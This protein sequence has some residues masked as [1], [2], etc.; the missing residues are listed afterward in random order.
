MLLLAI[1]TVEFGDERKSN[2]RTENEVFSVGTVRSGGPVV[3]SS[4]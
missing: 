1:R 4:F 2:V 3:F